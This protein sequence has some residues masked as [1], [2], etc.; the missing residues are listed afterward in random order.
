VITHEEPPPPYDR[1][2]Y[3]EDVLDLFHE[4]PELPE[5]HQ[6]ANEIMTEIW[7]ER[8]RVESK[9][10]GASVKKHLERIGKTRFTKYC[11]Q[12]ANYI[13]NETVPIITAEQEYK[14]LLVFLDL[15]EPFQKL[16]DSQRSSFPNYHLLFRLICHMFGWYQFIP[17]LTMLRTE[18]KKDDQLRL[19]KAMFA[20]RGYPWPNATELGL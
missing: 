11:N 1:R 8:T 2:N 18:D 19:L 5:M 20:D 13:N 10:T 17:Y 4:K 9:A 3:F 14:A 15:L 6:L 7:L 12:I 16:K